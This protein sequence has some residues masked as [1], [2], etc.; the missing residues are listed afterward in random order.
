MIY[1]ITTKWPPYEDDEEEG[2][3]N[4]DLQDGREN[5]AKEKSEK[6]DLIL[7]YQQEE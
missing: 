4:L 5:E 3:F 6:G 7:I 2:S 1:W